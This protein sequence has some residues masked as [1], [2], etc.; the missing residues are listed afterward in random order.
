MAAQTGRTTFDHLQF[1][2]DDSGGTLRSIPIDSINGVGLEYE[3]MELTAYQDAI[4]NVLLATPDCVIEITGPFDTSVVAAAGTLSGSHTVLNGVNGLMT[5]LS[6]DV[7]V[8]MRHAWEA[9]E[10]QFG[11]TATATAGFICTKYVPDLNTG[12]YSARFR[13][14]GGTAP[15]WGVAAES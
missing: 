10:P 15:A 14:M 2:V 4:K 12:K 9:G 6:L 7:Q 3:E 13:V 1:N 11:M 8:G 5:P